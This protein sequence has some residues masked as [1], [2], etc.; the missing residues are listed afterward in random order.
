MACPRRSRWA[1]GWLPGFLASTGGWGE[2]KGRA[3][4]E[5]VA[6]Q[7]SPR[8]GSCP[9][10]VMDA[11]AGAFF[12]HAPRRCFCYGSAPSLCCASLSGHCSRPRRAG[13][14]G[15]PPLSGGRLLTMGETEIKWRPPKGK[16]QKGSYLT[17]CRWTKGCWGRKRW[18]EIISVIWSR[19]LY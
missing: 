19:V 18:M 6:K 17:I 9:Y 15:R 11:C 5:P 10:P 3:W 14:A 12:N 2:Y 1:A 13:K 7:R 16:Q 4:P 8:S